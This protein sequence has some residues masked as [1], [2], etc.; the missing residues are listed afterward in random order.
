MVHNAPHTSSVLSTKSIS[1]DGGI[2]TYR[3]SVVVSKN[4]TDSKASVSCQSL[5]LDDISRSDTIPAMDIR[6]HKAILV[7]K[8]KSVVSATRQY[9]T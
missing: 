9:S 5:M 7:M 4:A 2:S 6:T 3:S 8:L 1:K